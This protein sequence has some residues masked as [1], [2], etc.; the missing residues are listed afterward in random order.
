MGR[1]TAMP[2]DEAVE[3]RRLKTRSEF[4]RA[5]RGKRAGRSAFLLQAVT[6]DDPEPGLGFTVTKRVGNAVERNRIRR[7]LR[8][9]ARACEAAFQPRHDYVII[10]RREALVEPFDKLVAD[11]GGAIA[12]IHT[13][14]A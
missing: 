3:V 5:A 14:K 12:R 9:A 8:E 10:G 1:A 11:I 2:T 6:R 4:V 7:R 13:S